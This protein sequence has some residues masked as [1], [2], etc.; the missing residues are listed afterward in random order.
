MYVYVVYCHPLPGIDNG[1]VACDIL[2]D[3]GVHSYPDTCN[4]TCSV[5]YVL[6]GS[7]SRMCLSD[8]SWSGTD[9]SCQGKIHVHCNQ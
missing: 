6:I 3:D 7:D 5:G 2:G 1:N 8:G 4:V 9:S